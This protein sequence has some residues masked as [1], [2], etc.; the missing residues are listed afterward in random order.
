VSRK[1]KGILLRYGIA[2]LFGA[3]LV[4]LVLHLHGYAA[5]T[6]EADRWKTLSNA[7]TI[8][9]SVLLMVG[10]LVL[11]NNTD[12]LDGLTYALNWLKTTLLPGSKQPRYTDYVEHRRARPK[13]KSAFLFIVGFAFLAVAVFCLIKFY[14][15]YTPKR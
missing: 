13:G 1:M 11:I 15:F 7:F 3:G 4:W 2:I 8:P 12:A 5:L 14:Q 6:E 9:A 10:V